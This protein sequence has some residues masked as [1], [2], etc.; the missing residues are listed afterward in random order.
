MVQFSE[1]V[2]EMEKQFENDMEKKKDEIKTQLA[3]IVKT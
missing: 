1:I 3:I 2:N